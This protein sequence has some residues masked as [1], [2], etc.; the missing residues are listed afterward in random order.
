[1]G[2]KLFHFLLL[3]VIFSLFILLSIFYPHTGSF[4]RAQETS[5]TYYIAPSG[6]DVLG[7]GSSDKPFKTIQHALDLAYAG[8]TIL[9]EAGTY[10]EHLVTK[11]NGTP[12]APITLKAQ[13]KVVLKGSDTTRIFDLFNDYYIIEGFEFDGGYSDSKDVTK[14]VDKLLWIET[15]RFNSIRYNNFHHAQGEC[16]RL[17]FF[18]EGN[19][20]EYNTIAN[21][22]LRDFVGYRSESYKNGEG[23]YIGTAPEQ[24]DPVKCKTEECKTL[25]AET[26][27]QK[28]GREIYTKNTIVDHNFFDTHGNECVDIKEGSSGN[29]IADNVCIS[30][31]DSQSAA[32]NTRGA[33]NTFLHNTVGYLDVYSQNLIDGDHASSTRAT[34]HKIL[35]AAFRAGG[36]VV[37][38]GANNNIVKNHVLDYEGEAKVV[39]KVPKDDTQGAVC[40]NSIAFLLSGGFSDN[41]KVINASIC[42]SAYTTI[43]QA[44]ARGCIGHT[45]QPISPSPTPTPTNSPT[46]TPSPTLT[47]TPTATPSPTPTPTPTVT[48]SPAIDI[49]SAPQ[50]LT[51]VSPSDSRVNLSWQTVSGAVKYN[52]YW[53]YSG[54]GNI[55]RYKKSSTSTNASVT[56][57]KS[58]KDYSFYVTALDVS[59]RESQQS[60]TVIVRVK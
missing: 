59:G 42:P 36:D 28:Y 37:G 49:L 58:G 41:S 29:V 30:Q 38:D 26:G 16:I 47:P 7:D 4:V 40:Q 20:F 54:W 14:T 24:I 13:G 15:A 53:T 9:V 50:N 18:S 44:G 21:C 60:N 45:C 6:D 55:F 22:G 8:T 11:K 39:V 43:E 3:P 27:L 48:P 57:A 12:L 56:G 25:I 2:S 1:M 5:M 10:K 33:A 46:S 52:L 34:G 23:I 31:Y 51:G 35:G 17:I 19:H 32:F